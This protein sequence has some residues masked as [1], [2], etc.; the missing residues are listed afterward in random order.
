MSKPELDSDDKLRCY[1]R[2]RSKR[3]DSKTLVEEN[4]EFWSIAL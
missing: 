1:K 3:S 4:I 2:A